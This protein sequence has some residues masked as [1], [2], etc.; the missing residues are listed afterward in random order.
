MSGAKILNNTAVAPWW[1]NG[2][3]IAGGKDV[4]MKDNLVN[5]VSSNSALHIGVF[6]DT[7]KQPVSTGTGAAEQV[8]DGKV[9]D[10]GVHDG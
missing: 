2:L 3:R 9:L 10:A 8:G 4:E 7:A 5:S 1:A 6:G